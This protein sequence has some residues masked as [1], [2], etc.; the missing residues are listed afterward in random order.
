MPPERQ[1]Y[2]LK[3]G[4]KLRAWTAGWLEPVPEEEDPE[5]VSLLYSSLASFSCM[6]RSLAFAR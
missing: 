5:N 6:R 2:V 3:H 1:H 4:S